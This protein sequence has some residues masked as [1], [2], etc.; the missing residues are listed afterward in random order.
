VRVLLAAGAA[1]PGDL[2]PSGDA[3][4][5]ALIGA[6]QNRGTQRGTA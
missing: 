3:Q 4:I 1:V 5:D 6:A 2:R